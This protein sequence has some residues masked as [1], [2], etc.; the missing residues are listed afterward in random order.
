MQNPGLTPTD[1]V[2]FVGSALCFDRSGERG[3]QLSLDQFKDS[4]NFDVDDAVQ[5]LEKLGIVSR[6]DD[7]RYFCDGFKHANDIIG[8]TTDE[9][10]SSKL[11]K[12]L[13]TASNLTATKEIGAAA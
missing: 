5:K 1:W 8:V 4:C 3:D 13:S 7:G 9:L 2:K 10:V 11:V 12:D 6:D